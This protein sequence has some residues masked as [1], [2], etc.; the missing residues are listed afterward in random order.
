MG[1]NLGID[2]SLLFCHYQYSYVQTVILVISKNCTN[3]KLVTLQK[4]KL[5]FIVFPAVLMLGSP[6]N[7]TVTCKKLQVC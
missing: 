1:E 4:D 6:E 7:I 3:Q 5:H 2:M